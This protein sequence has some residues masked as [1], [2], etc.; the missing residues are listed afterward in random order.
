MKTYTKVSI[1]AAVFTIMTVINLII[2]LEY[3][4]KYANIIDAITALEYSIV[5]PEM[6]DYSKIIIPQVKDPDIKIAKYKE[7]INKQNF[8]IYALR[9]HIKTQNEFTTELYNEHKQRAK[10]D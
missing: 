7:F 9:W 2:Y 8:L 1:T 3:K 10:G 5:H 4:I 6:D